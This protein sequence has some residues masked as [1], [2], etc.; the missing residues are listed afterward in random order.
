M[1]FITLGV[2]FLLLLTCQVEVALYFLLVA[3]LILIVVKGL[4]GILKW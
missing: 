2:F 4:S 3:R 1:P